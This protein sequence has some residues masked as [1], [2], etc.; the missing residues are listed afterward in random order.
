M[1]YTVCIRLLLLCLHVW[2][3][4]CVFYYERILGTFHWNW[5]KIQ[6]FSFTKMRLKMLSAN[7]WPF[8]PRGDELITGTQSS[9]NVDTCGISPG[10]VLGPLFRGLYL[11]NI[12]ISTFSIVVIFSAVVCLVWLYH[13]MLSVSNISRKAVLC[14]LYCCT[15]LWCVQIIE[16]M[17]ARWSYSFVCTLHYFIIIIMRT[18]LNA[19]H[20]W[21]TRQVHSLECVLKI[22]SILSIIFHATMGICMFSLPI[23]R[24]VIVRI[25]LHYLNNIN[26]SEE[27]PICHCFWFDHEKMLCAVYFPIYYETEYTTLCQRYYLSYV[28]LEVADIVLR[29]WLEM[30]YFCNLIYL[31]LGK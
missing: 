31:G 29:N 25:N 11:N 24:M 20:F 2:I 16:Y 15:V 7:R 21:I 23:Y 13:H 14:S 5:D 4:R 19:L 18:Y 17:M 8:N 10:F 12:I 26:K 6:R 30:F 27:W 9:S 1:V 3:V 28:E 22:K